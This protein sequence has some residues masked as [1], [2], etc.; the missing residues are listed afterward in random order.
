MITLNTR[1]SLAALVFALPL[2]ATSA[3][4]GSLEEPVVAVVPVAPA[5]YVSL[6]SGGYVGAQVGYGWADTD[7]SDNDV[8]N[9]GIVD[10]LQN[11]IGAIGEDGDGWLGGAFVGYRGN[12]NKFVYGAEASYDFADVQFDNNA[13]SIDG[14]GRLKVIGG[15]DLGK[16]L[17]YATA[18]A[19][20]GDGEI[21]N[22]SHADWGWLAGAGVDYM[23][24]DQ[25][26]VGAEALYQD[27]GE[28]GDSGTDVDLTTLEAR[29]SYHF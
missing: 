7:I 27:F 26:S 13:G 24:N 22:R 23:V 18:G 3:F 15:Y 4:A 1:S 12:A 6:W 8:N 5:P 28:F 16:T 2:G 19:A 17:I 21:N 10:S 29:V 25:W 20:Y 11:T 9:D 14:L